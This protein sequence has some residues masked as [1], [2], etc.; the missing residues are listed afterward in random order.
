MLF[1]CTFI[2][3]NDSNDTNAVKQWPMPD[4]KVEWNLE[5]IPNAGRP[6]SGVQ[7]Y[8]DLKYN[9]LFTRSRGW[10]GGDG[11]LSVGLPNGDV[12]WTFNDSFYGL[13][14]KDR[15]RG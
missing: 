5:L 8:K 2:S 13:V 6:A 3:C 11:V 15:T 1:S 12:L 14:G 10:N 4:I 9:K 7:V